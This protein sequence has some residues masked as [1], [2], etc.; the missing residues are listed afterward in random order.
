RFGKLTVI[1][2]TNQ[3][4]G[5]S[6]VWK[7]ICDCGNEVFVSS[8]KLTS[9]NTQSC[10]CIRKSN[11]GVTPI[12]LTGKRFGRLKV[13]SMTSKRSSKSVVWKCL[14]DCGNICEVSSVSLTQ[15]NTLSCGCLKEDVS[16]YNQ[17]RVITSSLSSHK[18][19]NNSS[20]V[21]GVCFDHSSNKWLATIGFN[22][23]DYYLCRS[24]DKDYAIQMRLKAEDE[25]LKPFLLEFM[26]N[27]NF[28]SHC[29][30]I[31]KKRIKDL[32]DKIRDK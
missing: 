23:K 8:R 5:G 24:E 3:R 16:K 14:C 9:G 17:V 22:G 21:T 27:D 7:C 1:E 12:D 20:G 4:E 11:T 31:L 26:E 25:I 10:G 30:E 29:D 15:G 19:S 13:I 18:R 2:K 32:R 6:I 28:P